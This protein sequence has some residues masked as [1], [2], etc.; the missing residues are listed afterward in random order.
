[1]ALHLD[2][3]AEITSAGKK[4]EKEVR[5]ITGEIKEKSM[6]MKACASGE[7]QREV[8]G[9]EADIFEQRPIMSQW[10]SQPAISGG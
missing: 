5:A 6:G 9:K 8:Q 2:G 7:N 10:W 3:P 4:V 1:M